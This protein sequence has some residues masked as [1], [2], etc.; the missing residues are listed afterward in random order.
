VVLAG[1]FGFG[2]WSLGLDLNITRERRGIRIRGARGYIFSEDMTFVSL[3]TRDPQVERPVRRALEDRHVVALS[4]GWDRL[5]H[6]V[7]E[8]PATCVILDEAYLPPLGRPAGALAELRARFPSVSVVWLARPVTDPSDLLRLGRA[9]VDSLLLVPVD[10]VER[11]VGGSVGRALGRGTEALVTREVSS[12]LP[13]RSLT[14]VRLALDDIHRRLSADDF[15]SRLGLS[16]PHLSVCLRAAG[17]PSAGH[18]LVW[19]RLLHA[20]RWLSDPGRSAESVSRQLDYSSGAAFRR[21]LKIYLGATPTQVTHR[22]GLAFVLERFVR[23]C[24]LDRD[25]RRGRSAA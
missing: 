11:D 22:G 2:G 17:L 14:A 20:G 12:Y 23:R 16:R 8:R 3:L 6:S 25:D 24:G 4:G 15:A 19:A 9:G 13:A 21:T 5:L 10:D 1:R 18:L 7:R